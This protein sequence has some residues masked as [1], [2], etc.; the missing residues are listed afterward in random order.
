MI[1]SRGQNG[2][3]QAFAFSVNLHGRNRITKARPFRQTVAH[4]VRV[5]PT[6]EE[7]EQIS[8]IFFGSVAQRYGENF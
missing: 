2:R 1:A 7:Q 6:R 5:A 8:F 3:Q 4:L